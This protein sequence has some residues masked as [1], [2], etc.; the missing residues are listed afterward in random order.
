MPS[1]LFSA[2]LRAN[3]SWYCCSLFSRSLWLYTSS[4]NKRE[5]HVSG[6]QEGACEAGAGTF[7]FCLLL[8]CSSVSAGL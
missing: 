7:S 6:G 4:C 3:S 8:I 2:F 1:R 5:A